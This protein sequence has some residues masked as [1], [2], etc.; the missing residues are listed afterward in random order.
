M[1]ISENLSLK[2]IYEVLFEGFSRALSDYA[3]ALRCYNATGFGCSFF[4]AKNIL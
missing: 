2:S 3:K 4:L 1:D